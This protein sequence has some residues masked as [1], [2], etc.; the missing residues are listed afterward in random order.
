MEREDLIETNVK[1]ESDNLQPCQIY[2]KSLKQIVD[3]AVEL[4]FP[5]SLSEEVKKEALTIISLLKGARGELLARNQEFHRE[6]QKLFE[7]EK[8][9]L[10]KIEAYTGELQVIERLLAECQILESCRGLLAIAR[11]TSPAVS[12]VRSGHLVDM[13]IAYKREAEL[14]FMQDQEKLQQV[15][16]AL[17]RT[18]EMALNH[19]GKLT[20]GLRQLATQRI[21][22]IE[23]RK[24]LSS[25]R[26]GC[27]LV[28]V[29]L[30]SDA[31]KQKL[32]DFTQEEK[33]AY[34]N[35]A[36]IM[37]ELEN[38]LEFTSLLLKMS[39]K[40]YSTKQLIE[41]VATII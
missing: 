31:L 34:N 5:V 16:L 22:K 6:I 37:K 38:A 32:A 18:K 28:I 15:T 29:L 4:F 36:D 8:K 41:S 39:R 12:A 10:K 35:S 23:D 2:K 11:D 3:A 26:R 7:E 20:E 9:L 40:N 27:L 1:G 33:K 21:K 25:L 13:Q 19:S 24:K 17:G 30:K 14:L